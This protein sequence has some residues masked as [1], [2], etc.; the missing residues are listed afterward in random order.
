M[1]D[2]QRIEEIEGQHNARVEYFL[3]DFDG[4]VKSTAP[5][6]TLPREEDVADL[7]AQIRDLRAEVEGLER[8]TEVSYSLEYVKMCA[9]GEARLARREQCIED[10]KAVCMR[11]REN[12]PMEHGYHMTGVLGL[13]Q[14]L[15]QAHA[16]RTANTNLLAGGG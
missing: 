6:S 10:C 12:V 4:Q 2:A 7:L 9:K 3:K 13:T 1:S 5:P 16:I 11:C 15:C 8:K 14:R